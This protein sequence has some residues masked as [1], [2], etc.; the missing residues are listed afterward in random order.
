MLERQTAGISVMLHMMKGRGHAFQVWSLPFGYFGEV[1]MCTYFNFDCWYCS[2]C[3]GWL[4]DRGPLSLLTNVAW[5]VGASCFELLFAVILLF[6]TWLHHRR[7]VSLSLSLDEQ[8]LVILRANFA[9]EI[10]TTNGPKLRPRPK[11][12][13]FNN[14]MR[15]WISSWPINP[16]LI[17]STSN[18]WFHT[19]I[20]NQHHLKFQAHSQL[21]H[22]RLFHYEFNQHWQHSRWHN[23]ANH[24]IYHTSILS[25]CWIR[26]GKLWKPTWLRPWKRPT[27]VPHNF[28]TLHHLPQQL[29]LLTVNIDLQAANFQP[30]PNPHVA[31]VPHLVH[32]NRI[33]M[34]NGTSLFPEAHDVVPALMIP[35]GDASPSHRGRESSVT[36]LSVSP[37]RRS[38]SYD[39]NQ[40]DR[41]HH[42]S[43]GRSSRP[44]EPSNPPAWRQPGGPSFKLRRPLRPP[45][46]QHWPL[47]LARLGRLGKVGSSVTTWPPTERGTTNRIL[48]SCHARQIHP[49]LL[50]VSQRHHNLGQNPLRRF[51]RHTMALQA[52][53]RN[54][55]NPHGTVPSLIRHITP[56]QPRQ[57]QKA[58]SKYHWKMIL[59]ETGSKRYGLP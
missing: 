19:N 32:G 22:H 47:H 51:P 23:Q 6:C 28:F 37:D 9:V 43:A 36:L 1:Q 15:C 57:F 59:R 17:S 41:T 26:W 2:R 39:V 42:S 48:I 13:H 16:W 54:R 31:H 56:G 30:R 33:G 46:P 21:N 27:N 29:H 7:H 52:N 53:A 50:H 14:S 44:A 8:W 5:I 10:W 49:D 38:Y 40:D 58:T 34:T 24:Q 18:S 12:M 3:W 55:P 11:S 20:L 45:G 25:R 35:A 4:D